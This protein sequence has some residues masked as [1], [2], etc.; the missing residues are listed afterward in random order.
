MLVLIAPGRSETHFPLQ[1]PPTKREKE[2]LKRCLWCSRVHLE[3]QTKRRNSTSYKTELQGTGN[4]GK[5]FYNLVWR[6]LHAV[7]GHEEPN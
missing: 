3:R 2:T 6:V 7:T 5:Y 1:F 4:G